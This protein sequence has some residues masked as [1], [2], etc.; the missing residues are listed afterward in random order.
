MITIFGKT[1]SIGSFMKGFNQSPFWDNPS[2]RGTSEIVKID[3]SH[4]WYK[5]GKTT[6]RISIKLINDICAYILNNMPKGRKIYTKDIV[7]I[8]ENVAPGYRGWHDCDAT[9]IMMLLRYVLKKKIDGKRPC[10]VI[11]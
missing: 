2:G 6:M 10:Y 4:I 3:S 11:I 9:F 1:F 5:R 7:L 8:K